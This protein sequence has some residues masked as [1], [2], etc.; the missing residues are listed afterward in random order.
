MIK[1]KRSW[2]MVSILFF[3]FLLSSGGVFF[4]EYKADKGDVAD[5]AA[6]KAGYHSK[7]IMFQADSL[8]D[9]QQIAAQYN[10]KLRKH[11]KAISSIRGRCY[12]VFEKKP[13]NN[14][15]VEDIV[16]LLGTE[17]GIHSA[18]LDY[19]VSIALTPNDTKYPELWGMNNTGQ[20]GG[21]VDADIDAPEA[22][23]LATGSTGVI[24][25]VVD[26]GV[27]YNHTDLAPNMW[28][29]PGEIAGNGI[30]DDGN[31]YIDDI[32]G[33][34]ACNN[35]SNPMDDHYHGTHCAGTIGAK[36]NDNYGVAGVNWNVKLMALKF[37]NS[38][39]SG[40]YSDALECY[41]Y[42][43][44]MKQRGYNIVAH[45]NSWGGSGFDQ[46][47]LDA[48]DTLGNLGVLCV[49]AAGNN[50]VDTD[51]SPFYPAAF[52]SNFIISVAAIDH[53]DNLASFSNWGKNTV[54]LAAPGV[55]IV[56][57]S[58][59][60]GFRTLNGTS[61]ATPH[62]SGVVGLLASVFSNDTALERKS[63]IMDY[64]DVT[65][66]MT[67]KCV[68]NGRL[69]AFKAL[70]SAPFVT[71]NF[72]YSRQGDLTRVFT[73]LSTAYQCTITSWSWNFGDSQTSTQQNPTHTY[74]ASGFYDVT[75]TVTANT[76]ATDSITKSVW[77]GPNLVPTANFTYTDAGG[78]NVY[79]TDTSI[80]SD[81]SVTQWYWQFGDGATS[82]VQNPSHHYQWPGTYTVTLTAT[83]NE[84]GS[85][86]ETKLVV[87]ELSYCV[88]SSLTADP[89][90]ITKV[91]IGSFSNPSG[92]STYTDFMN[93]TANMNRGQTYNVTI[94][95]DST[96]WQA[97]VRIW[98]DYNLDGDFDDANE[99]V[100]ESYGTGTVTGSFT[101]STG[102]ITGHD[103]GMR[104]SMKQASY[105]TACAASDGWGEVEDYT[106]LFNGGSNQP[107][108]A[109]FTYTA[110]GLTVNFTDT[111]TDSDGTIT[112]WSW[113]FGDSGTST[114]ENPSHTYAAD[115]TYTVTLTVTDN[116]GATDP[117]SKNVTVSGGGVLTY[118]S[119]SSNNCNDAYLSN[120]VIGTFSKSSSGRNY[121]DFTDLTIDLVKG[122]NYSISL[123]PYMNSTVYDGYWRIWID[124][125]RNGVLNDT[126]EKVFEGWMQDQQSGQPITGSF[127]VP[128]SGV[129]TGQM[130]VMRISFRVNDYR[131]VC[132][133]SDG[134][135]EVE[136]YGILIQ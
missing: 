56:S 21:T 122:N 77:A 27:D 78:F 133:K 38:S 53:N 30:D 128:S 96:F 25:A 120:V 108:T 83:D 67:N 104:V 80:D 28:H 22:W 32:Y 3:I 88:S 44:A 113:D 127:T 50:S 136:D 100:M 58:P 135:G 42:L 110:N 85:D 124:Y 48:I 16:R 106:A 15:P 52:N 119:S 94:T 87:V 13:G 14:I 60:N 123:T 121:K 86:S 129:V 45:S 49:A 89:V 47:V 97:N 99:K 68:T 43:I 46:A 98:I 74:A 61:M 17:P 8:A 102:A 2:F 79:F 134:K 34:D 9:A 82:T 111:S 116:D 29:N 35:D 126:G 72:S 71:A 73:D 103:V 114:Q 90:A 132:E 115:G 19:E 10:L 20:T 64:V 131:N 91:Q 51:V 70:Q 40:S 31:G 5:E 7:R 130:L 75:L 117:E 107:P 1:Q 93:L 92:K 125:N 81:G 36:G 109:N 112:A 118:C 69:N 63:R 12:G 18:N 59:G 6:K 4:A 23:D 101:V 37:L 54:D 39:G 62:V 33:I 57:D 24:I 55:S 65:S 95:T 66:A 76:G 26:T 84:G 41:N 11:F 105:R